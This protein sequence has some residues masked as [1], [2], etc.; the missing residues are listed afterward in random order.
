MKL[1]SIKAHSTFAAL[2][3][4][5]AVGANN[6]HAEVYKWVDENGDVQFSDRVPAEDAK[7]GHDILNEQGRVVD[8]VDSEKTPEEISKIREQERLA[9]IKRQ[10]AEKQIAHDKALLKSFTSIDELVN[11]HTERMGL[12]DQTIL[13]SKGRIR[14]QQV[15]L[16][17]LKKRRQ[18]FIDRDMEIPAWLEENEF[19]VLEKI[20]IIE[21]YIRGREKEKKELE[22]EF[23]KDFAR[24]KEITQSAFN[25][26]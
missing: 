26:R 6:A 12:I 9:E 22:I 20:A 18:G 5:L 8:S 14:K 15:E 25:S 2:I 16:A 19:L 7:Y 1:I 4:S 21:E 10:E 17:K 23:Q 24:Y 3:F 11:A 13:V